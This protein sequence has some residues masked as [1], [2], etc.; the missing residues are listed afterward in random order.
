MY[1]H[2]YHTHVYVHIYIQIIFPFSNENIYAGM[3]VNAIFWLAKHGKGIFMFK[4]VKD[5]IRFLML[6]SIFMSAGFPMAKKLKNYIYI[7][8]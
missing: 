1:I 2:I 5:E 3:R 6:Q 8:I 4:M 7:C